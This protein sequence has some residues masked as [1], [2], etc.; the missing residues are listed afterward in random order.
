LGSSLHNQ[1]RAQGIVKKHH[2]IKFIIILLICAFG[3]SFAYRVCSLLQLNLRLEQ[4]MAQQII[5]IQESHYDEEFFNAR[6]FQKPNEYFVFRSE[7]YYIYGNSFIDDMED[8]YDSYWISYPDI[9]NKVSYTEWKKELAKYGDETLSYSYQ[10]RPGQGSV[11][12]V[13]VTS[14]KPRSWSAGMGSVGTSTWSIDIAQ[15][16]WQLRPHYDGPCEFRDTEL[17]RTLLWYVQY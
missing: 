1:Q 16:E 13:L 17:L 7:V 2:S 3:A 8:S 9:Q 12:C 15:E 6:G 4:F 10:I 5:E 14:L 11:V